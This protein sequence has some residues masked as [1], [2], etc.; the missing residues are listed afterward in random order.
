MYHVLLS[1]G[2][3]PYTLKVRFPGTGVIIA[4]S[5]VANAQLAGTGL[6]GA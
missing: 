3:I 4:P 6:L 2:V 5:P 1:S